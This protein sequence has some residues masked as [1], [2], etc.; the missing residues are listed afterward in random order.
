[1]PD[2]ELTGKS[3]NQVQAD[4]ENNVDSGKNDDL[5]NIR[6][7]KDRSPE[8]E[9]VD[10]RKLQDDQQ[11]NASCRKQQLLH[12]FSTRPFPK[13]PAGFNSRMSIKMEKAIAS[14]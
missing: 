14:R 5:M 6:T 13:I 11:N 7:L 10:H 1:M 8:K 2:G 3:V 4:S 9:A 12:T